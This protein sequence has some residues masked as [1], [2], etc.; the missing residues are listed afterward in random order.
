[1]CS[2]VSLPS[3]NGKGLKE[4]L[5]S[6]AA[7]NDY[8]FS[9]RFHVSSACKEYQVYVHA[10]SDARC[11]FDMAVSSRIIIFKPACY[12]RIIFNKY[13]LVTV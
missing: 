4:L 11:V 8:L 7:L 6:H 12:F 13:E 1:M 3:D 9:F 2:A 10:L 5:Q